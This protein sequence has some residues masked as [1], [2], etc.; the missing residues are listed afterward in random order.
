MPPCI[1]NFIQQYPSHFRYTYSSWGLSPKHQ[2]IL[3]DIVARSK[4]ADGME[5]IINSLT[6]HFKSEFLCSCNS[7]T[8]NSYITFAPSFDVIIAFV[9]L[10]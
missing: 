3:G 4:L 6:R 10:A 2:D 9:A 7:I 5:S 1:L 8:V